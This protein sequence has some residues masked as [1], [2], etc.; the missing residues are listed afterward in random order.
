MRVNRSRA[1]Q[2]LSTPHV[3]QKPGG[4]PSAQPTHLIEVEALSPWRAIEDD[5]A[6][7]A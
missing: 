3:D 2:T 1:G 5:V 6:A 4:E 7:T